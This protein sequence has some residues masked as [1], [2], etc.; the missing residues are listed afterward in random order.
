MPR[1]SKLKSPLLGFHALMGIAVSAL[2]GVR[3]VG[4]LSPRP[5]ILPTPPTWQAVMAS[6]THLALYGL[7]IVTPLLAWLMLSAALGHHAAFACS[8]RSC[9]GQNTEG[10]A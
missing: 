5:P 1:G 2:V 10:L 3:L 4:R 6:I 7:M 9:V 8:C